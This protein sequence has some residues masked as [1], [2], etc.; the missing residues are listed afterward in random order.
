MRAIE[1]L[2][3]LPV[4]FKLGDR[5]VLLAGAGTG[6][7]WKAELLSATGAR[8]RLC[9]PAAS[10]ELVEAVTRLV[11]VEFCARR[12][13]EGD[14]EGVALAILDAADDGEA[15]AFRAAARRCGAPVNVVDRPEFCDFSFGSVVNRSPLIVAIST[16]GAAPVFGQALRVRIEAML[17]PALKAWAAAARDW[18]ARVAPL[19]WDFRRRRGFWERFAELA[20]GAGDRPPGDGDFAALADAADPGAAPAE[21]R[22]TLVG[23]GPGDPELLTLKAVRSLQSADVILYDSLVGPGALE[24]ARREALREDVGK[25]AGAPSPKQAEITARMIAL[26]LSGK[27][28]VR[29]KGGDPGVFGRAN[30]E[31]SAARA[32]GVEVEIVPGVTTALAAGAE[33]GRSLTDRDLAPRLQLATVSDRDGEAPDRLSWGA[34]ADPHATTAL[35]MGARKLG[36]IV[37]RL[38]AEGL[39][40]ATPSVYLEN[41]SRPDARRIAAPL[42]ELPAAVAARP[43]GGGPGLVLYGRALAEGEP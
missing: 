29:L 11:G 3:T 8:V 10:V 42:C 25:R 19:G 5:P 31:I 37:E 35:Y 12:W 20:L 30:E 21:G 28:V 7:A 26:A 34:L 27:R 23:A 9:A 40:P 38:I 32:A 22:I 39:D 41:V 36:A 24:L 16:D 43:G 18:R 33:L 13:E 4:F 14:F 1:P 6:I 15:Q 2:A 17:P